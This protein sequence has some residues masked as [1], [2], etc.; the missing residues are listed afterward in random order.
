MNEILDIEIILNNNKYHKIYDISTIL[1]ICICIF[2]YVTI[3]YNYQTYYITKGRIIDNK[4]ELMVSLENIKYITNQ[5]N[6]ILDNNK[7]YNYKIVRISDEI[8]L[9][10]AYNNYKYIY[11]EVKNLNN[12]DNYVYDLK[13]KKENKKI[14]EYLKDYL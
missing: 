6:L 8:Y 14:I 12:I 2:I 11:L 10:E 13:I 4:L 3:M 5:N 1:I 7:T 9:D